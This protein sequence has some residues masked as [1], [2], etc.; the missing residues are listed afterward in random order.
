M[1]SGFIKRPPSTKPVCIV[2]LD[3]R[4]LVSEG[5]ELFGI[6]HERSL[7]G[8][9]RDYMSTFDFEQ[10]TSKLLQ[11]G[12]LTDYP[13]LEVVPRGRALIRNRWKLIEYNG[14]KCMSGVASTVQFLDCDFVP[15]EPEK[16]NMPAGF[17]GAIKRKFGIEHERGCQI[18]LTRNNKGKEEL[19]IDCEEK[20]LADRLFALHR[21]LSRVVQL[22][23]V[24]YVQIRLRGELRD[25]FTPDLSLL[26][27]GNPIMAPTNTNLVLPTTSVSMTVHNDFTFI[28]DE[29]MLGLLVSAD[30]NLKVI[31]W[32]DAT[33]GIGLAA[34][35]NCAQS[36]GLSPGE[37]MH[38]H[39]AVEVQPGVKTWIPEEYDRFKSALFE[40][41]AIDHFEYRAHLYDGTLVRMTVNAALGQFRKSLIRL[42][43]VLEC[44][45]V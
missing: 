43:K 42:V 7:L 25:R 12:E 30:P 4:I 22:F 20:A 5:S 8:N 39:M 17:V 34:G 6:S 38:R 21:K 11:R 13:S 10:L 16:W 40:H 9:F 41:T 15:P 26:E 29:A 1:N 24:P 35:V 14:Q 2:G 31:K 3:G 33:G 36:S 19:V 18:W 45:P 23:D 44:T 32:D 28:P 27:L 37:W